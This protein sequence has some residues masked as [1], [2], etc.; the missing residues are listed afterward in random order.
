MVV[1]SERDRAPD[2]LDMLSC[3]KQK[4]VTLTPT[5][6]QFPL[7]VLGRYPSF[8]GN[9]FRRGRPLLKPFNFWA[10]SY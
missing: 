2:L 1:R 10:C 5:I 6:V 8:G 3:Q 9:L 7:P 4:T